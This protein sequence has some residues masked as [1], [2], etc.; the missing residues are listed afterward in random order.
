MLFP[1]LHSFYPVLVKCLQ[2]S[3]RVNS[4]GLTQHNWY[5]VLHSEAAVLPAGTLSAIW[6]QWGRGGLSLDA[7]HPQVTLSCFY[8]LRSESAVQQRRKNL[9]AKGSGKKRKVDGSA[10]DWQQ[11]GRPLLIQQKQVTW[12]AAL[13]DLQYVCQL[14]LQVFIQKKQ[15]EQKK[16]SLKCTRRLLSPASHKHW[17]YDWSSLKSAQTSIESSAKGAPVWT[18]SPM[19]LPVHRE[20]GTKC[21]SSASKSVNWLIL[22][23]PFKISNHEIFMLNPLRHNPLIRTNKTITWRNRLLKKEDS[24]AH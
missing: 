14:L 24:F 3:A 4:H 10:P 1:E 23:N 12:H 21:P 11:E 6:H 7:S 5:F 19:C 17:Y 16:N 20:R 13:T 8:A 22:Y 18:M 2:S 9:P 15:T